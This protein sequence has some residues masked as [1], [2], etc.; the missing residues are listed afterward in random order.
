LY[1]L[2]K[3]LRHTRQG[4]GRSAML[5][6]FLG[7]LQILPSTSNLANTVVNIFHYLLYVSRISLLLLD[8]GELNLLIMWRL[9]HWQIDDSH[10]PRLLPSGPTRAHDAMLGADGVGHG[11]ERRRSR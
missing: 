7:F 11:C 8:H 5:D 3:R 9:S 1:D 4:I 6:S 10:I 2:G